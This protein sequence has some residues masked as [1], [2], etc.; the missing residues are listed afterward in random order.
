MSELKMEIPQEIV[1]SIVQAQVVAALGKSEA[2]I[3]AVVESAMMQK[4]NSYDRTTVFEEQVTEMIRAVAVE[5]FKE[6]LEANRERVRAEMQKQLTAQKNKLMVDLV[7]SFTRNLTNIYTT[8]ALK[9]GD[10]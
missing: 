2:L 4:N 10:Q 3:K 9:F 6:W 1:K 8:V 5:S 7:E